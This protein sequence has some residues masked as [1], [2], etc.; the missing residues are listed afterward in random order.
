MKYLI[1]LAV[2]AL[3]WW[4][5]RH[6]QRSQARRAASPPPTPPVVKQAMVNCPVCGLHLP[7]ADAVPGRV[8]HYC[9]EDH[10]ARHE[11]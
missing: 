5:W 10:R 3:A 11:H 8:A 6:H 9:S 4:W 2:V 1:W 7:Q